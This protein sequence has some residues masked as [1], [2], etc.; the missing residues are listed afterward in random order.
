MSF[1]PSCSF[2]LQVVPH[3]LQSPFHYLFFDMMFQKIIIL[4]P[5]KVFVLNLSKEGD[6][7]VCFQ[8][9]FGAKMVVT[10][11][12]GS[13]RMEVPWQEKDACHHYFHHPI[14]LR[15]SMFC[16]VNINMALNFMLSFS[17]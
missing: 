2:E 16:M 12:Q 10:V 9:H 5:Q 15:S 4:P 3:H 14:L 13:A 7:F 6:F 17:K 8:R 1:L 11:T